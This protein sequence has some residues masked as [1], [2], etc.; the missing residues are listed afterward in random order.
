[1]WSYLSVRQ[2]RSMNTLP[3]ARPTPS[4]EIATSASFN[5]LVNSSDV[6]CDPWT[7]SCLSSSYFEVSTR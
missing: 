4:I 6:N 2:K 5:T 1:M 7:L 3:I